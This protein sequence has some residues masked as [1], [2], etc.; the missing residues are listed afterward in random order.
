MPESAPESAVFFESM[1]S[2]PRT[3]SSSHKSKTPRRR[4]S[5][6]ILSVL[7]TLSAMRIALP[8]SAVTTSGSLAEDEVWT[9]TVILTDTV[10]V[11]K[12]VTLTIEAGTRV[13]LP[14]LECS[15][16]ADLCPSAVLDVRGSLI[17]VGTEEKKVFFSSAEEFQAEA[18]WGGINLSAESVQIEHCLIEY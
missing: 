14:R 12:G 13:L 18:D 7:L 6:W 9:G 10:H 3:V 4:W 1:T 11:P 17:A 5:A 8:A 2:L 15:P 16:G